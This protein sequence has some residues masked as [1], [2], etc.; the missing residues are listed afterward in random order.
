[1]FI[2]KAD[3]GEAAADMEEAAAVAVME[4]DMKF[5]SNT[6]KAAETVNI[7]DF[8]TMQLVLYAHKRLHGNKL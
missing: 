8:F 4:E 7:K 2:M 1:M 5:T 6:T 3:M